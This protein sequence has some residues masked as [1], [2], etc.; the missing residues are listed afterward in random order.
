MGTLLGL[1]ALPMY[2][3][4]YSLANIL[5]PRRGEFA[6]NRCFSCLSPVD[7]ATDIAY[8][9]DVGTNGQL[10][11]FLMTSANCDDNKQRTT[12]PLTYLYAVHRPENQVSLPQLAFVILEY[13]VYLSLDFRFSQVSL[14]VSYIA[15]L[16]Q[17]KQQW[18]KCS[19]R[20]IHMIVVFN[21]YVYSPQM[22]RTIETDRKKYR[23]NVNHVNCTSQ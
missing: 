17:Y 8:Y 4:S 10:Q 14:L 21:M 15:I 12:P 7:T 19:N 18:I 6:T 22:G 2:H 16:L 5:L 1:T 13:S 20:G 11:Q 9:K 3:S 23:I